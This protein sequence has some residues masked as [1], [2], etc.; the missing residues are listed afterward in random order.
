MRNFHDTD[1]ADKTGVDTRAVRR[2]AKIGE[3]ITPAKIGGSG[4][5]TVGAN[6]G[7]VAALR[8]LNCCFTSLASP[9]ARRH[10]P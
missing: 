9:P 5:A 4:L 7:K 6:S 10:F 3:K 8:A 1:Q 2:N